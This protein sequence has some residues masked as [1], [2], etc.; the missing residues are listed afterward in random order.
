MEILNK[1]FFNKS[2]IEISKN[3]LGVYLVH[4]KLVGKIVETEAYLKND[5]ASHAFKGK[6]ERNK[7]V[8]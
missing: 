2:T 6:T 8:F 7:S 4:G 5:P 1:Y 3:L